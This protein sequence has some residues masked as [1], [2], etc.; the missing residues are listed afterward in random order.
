MFIYRD[1]VYNP[2]SVESRGAAEVIVAKHRNGP[3][4]VCK[5]AFLSPYTRFENMA[6]L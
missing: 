1:E 4:G 3:T 6:R 2:E 5:L